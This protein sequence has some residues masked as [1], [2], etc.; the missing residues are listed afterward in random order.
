M[1][2]P[3]ISPL[4]SS[5]AGRQDLILKELR[6]VPALRASELA[7]RLGVSH[8]TIRRDLMDL[9]RRGL[10]N[11]T[12]GGAARPFSFEAPVNARRHMHV[13]DRERIAARMASLIAAKEVV[14]MGS[15]ATVWHAARAIAAE[16]QDV[17]VI[18]NDHAVAAAV[19]ANPSHRVICLG[20]RLQPEEGFV[21][22]TQALEAIA[23]YQANWAIIGA[24]GIDADGAYDIDD[25]AA[26]VYQAMVLRSA[27]VALL[28]D[29]SKFESPALARLATWSQ[30]DLLITDA[31]PRGAIAHGLDEAN[32][33]VVVAQSPSDTVSVA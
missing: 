29:R 19:G 22:G 18:T 6:L 33:S 26:S 27:R 25:Q 1:T 17:T 12:Y 14:M 24:S 8:E 31:R 28:A 7:Q 15:G 11:R 30:I 9:D 20:G 13:E 32:V 5:K 4:R 3:D 23:G 10:L 21:Y 16:R 2:S